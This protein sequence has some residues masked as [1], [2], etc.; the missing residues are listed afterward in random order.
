M[1]AAQGGLFRPIG[2]IANENPA[3]GSQRGS[4]RSR[5][6]LRTARDIACAVLLAAFSIVFFGV[7]GGVVAFVI[8]EAALI[9]VDYLV[10]NEGDAP[11]AVVR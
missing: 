2:R 9:G 8:L 6:P 11:S 1:A 4:L 10:P 5:A 7:L 3:G